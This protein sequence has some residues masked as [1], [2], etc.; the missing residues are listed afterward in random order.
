[1]KANI[2]VVAILLGLSTATCAKAVIFDCPKMIDILQTVDTPDKS[3]E[4][5]ADAGLPQASLLTVAVY[6]Q[7][8]SDA[9]S[10]VPD[11]SKKNAQTEVTIWRLPPDSAPYW[12]ACVYTNSRILLAKKISPE[13]KQC[14][15]TEALRDQQPNGVVSFVCE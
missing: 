1:M 4:Q 8:P 10:L 3:W 12:M 13:A 6:T 14:S 5:V 15:L 9:G 11:F 7:H 2:L